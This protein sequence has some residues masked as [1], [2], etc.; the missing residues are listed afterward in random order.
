MCCTL[1]PAV[2]DSTVLLAHQVEHEG[3]I[4]NVIGYQ[5]NAESKVPRP[6]AMI[7]PIP[8]A[9]I[10]TQDNCIDMTG[11]SPAFK[12]YWDIV[13]PRSRGMNLSKGAPVAA[14]AAPLDVFD[15]GSYTVLLCR[16]ARL[17]EIR[18][19][20]ASLPEGKRIELDTQ[21][22]KIFNAYKKLYPL[23]HIAICVWE[24]HVEA[25]PILWWYDPM[26]EYVERHFLP[27]LDAHDGT[28][29]R[30]G[31]WVDVDH[32]VLVGH[33]D[34]FDASS[35]VLKAPEH[36]RKWLPA[37]VFGE[38][39]GGERTNGDWV[40]PKNGWTRRNSFDRIMHKIRAAPPGAE[41]SS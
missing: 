34:G 40:F 12:E 3:R 23:W 6:N 21:K 13:R 25:E 19:A 1:E 10:M 38:E 29:P 36:L 18:E 30:A 11:A 4:V 37:N 22:A 9:E 32:T 20:L 35:A 5:N 41:A 26:P 27:G 24:G 15:S 39:M 14:A 28:P 16:G 8:S 33:P 7:I 31:E 17:V 2:L